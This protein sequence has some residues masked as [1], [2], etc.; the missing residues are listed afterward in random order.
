MGVFKFTEDQRPYR[1]QKPRGDL[2]SQPSFINTPIVWKPGFADGLIPIKPPY[3]DLGDGGLFPEEH[4]TRRRAY[5]DQLIAET[6]LEIRN[7]Q[8]LIGYW[9]QQKAS[10]QE[11]SD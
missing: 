8:N 1:Y 2:V 5:Y 11:E 10:L 9:E 7:H 4:K 6:Q 3:A